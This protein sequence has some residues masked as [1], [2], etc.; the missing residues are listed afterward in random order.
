MLIAGLLLL[1]VMT[2]IGVTMFRSFG[3]QEVMAGNLREKTRAFDSAQAAL[4]YGEWWLKQGNYAAYGTTCSSS[5]GVIPQ[6][7]NNPVAGGG[8]PTSLSWPSWVDYVPFGMS[9]TLGMP[10]VNTAGGSDTYYKDPGLYIQY[11]GVGGPNN[12]E[13][14]Y[15]VTAYGYG[16]NENSV[17]V[18]QSTYGVGTGVKSLSP[19]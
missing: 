8:S 13:M 19:P 7:C 15:Q 3:L 17:A 12:N 14:L 10:T 1:L 6:V 4:K 2:I 5:L 18:V 16:G 9:G 11:L